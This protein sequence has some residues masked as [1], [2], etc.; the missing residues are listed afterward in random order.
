MT[1]RLLNL[2][3]ALSL[4]LCV[5]VAVLWV[6]SYQV[7][8][9]VGYQSPRVELVEWRASWFLVGGS[10]CYDQLYSRIPRSAEQPAAV[11]RGLQLQFAR[12]A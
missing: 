4:L 1:R 9:A 10:L 5:A 3:T 8:Y 7:L 6:L 12:P 2:L 11:G